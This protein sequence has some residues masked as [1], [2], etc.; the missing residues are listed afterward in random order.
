[1][2][3]SLKNTLLLALG[4][5]A[6]AAS[7]SAQT[8]LQPDYLWSGGFYV[9]PQ[10]SLA[11]LTL[12]T[13]PGFNQVSMEIGWQDCQ[14]ESKKYVD[15]KWSAPVSPIGV[16]TQ[17]MIAELRLT[18]ALIGDLIAKGK[19]TLTYSRTWYEKKKTVPSTHWQIWRFL[20]NG[21]LRY[22]QGAKG[23]LRPNCAF[24]H[25][26]RVRYTGYVDWALDINKGTWS[27]TWML[28]HATDDLEHVPSHPREGNYHCDRSYSFV[29]PAKGFVADPLVAT[30]GGS[31]D[32]EYYRSV[33]RYVRR[34]KIGPPPFP[35]VP[36]PVGV[37]IPSSSFE[38]DVDFTVTPMYQMCPCSSAG[39]GL[40]QFAIAQMNIAGK[41]GS[42][43]QS[44]NELVNEFVSMGIGSWTDPSIYPG[45]EDVR[46]TI[47]EYDYFE[48]CTNETRKEVFHGVTTVGG[49]EAWAISYDPYYHSQ[50]LL[51]EYLG[52]TFIDQANARRKG[53]LSMNLPFKSDPVLTLNH[54]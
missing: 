35:P 54:W 5:L 20:V 29:G 38:E 11:P 19:M 7:S 47:A 46:W 13:F 27:N 45:V 48:P 10:C 6:L 18:E 53:R 52:A 3:N 23:S 42:T 26:G 36:G 8:W 9:N 14:A 21:D 34:P 1:M 33:V 37:G 12:P 51:K 2:L 50:Q 16:S 43:A 4:A 44:N 39:A 40:S 15:A 17:E 41:F 32:N 28:T 22:S 49:Y 30:E 31:Q 25:K 24:N